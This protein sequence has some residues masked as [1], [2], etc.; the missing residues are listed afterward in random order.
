MT[1]LEQK[2]AAITEQ[3]AR[4]GLRARELIVAVASGAEVPMKAARRFIQN[5]YPGLLR[6][7]SKVGPSEYDRPDRSPPPRGPIDVS[8]RDAFARPSRIRGG[9]RF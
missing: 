2:I 3:H 1:P 4:A 7:A 6:P 8:E 9:Y 5:R